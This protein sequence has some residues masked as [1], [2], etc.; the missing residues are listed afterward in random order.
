MKNKKTI[1]SLALDIAEESCQQCYEASRTEIVSIDGAWNSPRNAKFCIV[2]LIDCVTRK[3][4]DFQIVTSLVFQEIDH[5]HL[6]QGVT[7]APNTFESIG[8]RKIAKRNPLSK[9]NIFVHD[10][11]VKLTKF[12]Y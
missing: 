2:D 8:A 4:V 9:A 5:K 6:T 7:S 11:D 12:I 1:L 10:Q 3:L